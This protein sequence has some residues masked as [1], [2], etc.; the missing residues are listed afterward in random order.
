MGWGQGRS[1]SWNR[2]LVPFCLAGEA[3]RQSQLIHLLSTPDIFTFPLYSRP[4]KIVRRLLNKR[5]ILARKA[6]RYL[7][8]IHFPFTSSHSLPRIL[9][10]HK[11]CLVL[12]ASQKGSCGPASCSHSVDS[13]PRRGTWN[14]PLHQGRKAL[15]LAPRD[16]WAEQRP[17]QQGEVAHTLVHRHA[18]RHVHTYTYP[19]TR[20]AHIHTHRNNL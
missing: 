8:N 16:C 12:T 13:L 9:H 6:H 1:T 2:H 3:E 15:F 4:S 11:A 7:P 17:W 14:H 20:T 19:C 10:F 5:E 18:H